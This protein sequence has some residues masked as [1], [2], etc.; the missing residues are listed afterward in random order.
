MGGIKIKFKQTNHAGPGE[1]GLFP[2]ITLTV[3]SEQ[4]PGMQ[5]LI[6]V[7]VTPGL[8]AGEE[9]GWLYPAIILSADSERGPGIQSTEHSW[10]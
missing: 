4:G 6:T 8:R 1:G 7:W 9:W 5:L 3:D 2:A 10:T